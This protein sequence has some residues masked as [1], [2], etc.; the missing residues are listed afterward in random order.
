MPSPLSHTNTL[1]QILWLW[2]THSGRWRVSL[3][4]LSA[5]VPLDFTYIATYTQRNWTNHLQVR[6]IFDAL[7]QHANLLL[8]NNQ[9]RFEL[10]FPPVA[11][12]WSSVHHAGEKN[13][14]AAE[15]LTKHLVLPCTILSSTTSKSNLIFFLFLFIRGSRETGNA[16]KQRYLTTAVHHNKS[17][18]FQEIR[19]NYGPFSAR[20]NFERKAQIDGE[21]LSML[22]GEI[23]YWT[24]S[25]WRTEAR[26]KGSEHGESGYPLRGKTGGWE[27]LKNMT[28]FE[29]W[30]NFKSTSTIERWMDRWMNR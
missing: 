16:A 21:Q 23:K 17:K 27:Y 18:M 9:A 7:L 6:S 11:L 14:W 1:R 13:W 28:D 19:R 22:D 25:V 20:V 24:Y 8:L 10:P 29:M 26:L 5:S 4:S 30:A 15:H 3:F 12:T 2:H